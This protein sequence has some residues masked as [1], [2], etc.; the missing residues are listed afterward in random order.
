MLIDPKHRP[1]N[2]LGRLNSNVKITALDRKLEPRV[3]IF[4]E[5]KGNLKIVIN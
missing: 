4:D 1:V 3:F 2:D 5:M